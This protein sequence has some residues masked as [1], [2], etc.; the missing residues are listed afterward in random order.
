[1]L[2]LAARGLRAPSDLF[3]HTFFQKA[4]P[5]PKKDRDLIAILGN[6]VPETKSVDRT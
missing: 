2:F 6:V 3:S 5:K 1:M 4:S